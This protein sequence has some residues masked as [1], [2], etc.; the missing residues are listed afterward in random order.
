MKKGQN[1]ELYRSA[2]ELHELIL[3]RSTTT[4]TILRKAR[5]VAT[6]SGDKDFIKWIDNELNGDSGPPVPGYRIVNS[7][8]SLHEDGHIPYYYTE[9]HKKELSSTKF[10]PYKLSE[11]VSKLESILA[12]GGV[13]FR[14]AT[15]DT[16]DGIEIYKLYKVDTIAISEVLDK[17]QDLV[18]K[19]IERIIAGYLKNPASPTPSSS[20]NVDLIDVLRRFNDYRKYSKDEIN[21]EDAVRANTY[22]I[23]K[24]I[25]PDMVGEEYL[26]RFGIKNP[27]VD[28]AIP[29]IKTFVENKYVGAT[30]ELP[31]VQEEI[32]ADIP[33]YLTHYKDQYDGIVVFIYSKVH[34]S[35]DFIDNLKQQKGII[36]VIPAYA[37]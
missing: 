14:G 18:A 6:I 12:Q 36:D 28:F 27:K 17:I 8:E 9:A 20:K 23:L 22:L 32:L 10:V 24:A 3:A 21:D 15:F 29:S 34:I 19:K 11:S 2:K 5:L 30:K 25:F 4:Q 26:K 37:L 7:L 13:N 35:S 1:L 33:S 31:K 16:V